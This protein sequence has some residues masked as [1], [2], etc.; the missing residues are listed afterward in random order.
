MRKLRW[1]TLFA[2]LALVATACAE[3]TTTTTA[4]PTTTPPPP[5]APPPPA[6]PST[7]PVEQFQ[8]LA[9]SAACGTDSNTSE[10]NTIEAI[11]RLTV[12]FTLCAPDP[13][14]P[15]KVAFTSFPIKSA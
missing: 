3:D 8:P 10:F 9:A 15:S 12:K 4:A 7:E 14:F 11:D 6:P 13:A 5:T 2:V 1:L